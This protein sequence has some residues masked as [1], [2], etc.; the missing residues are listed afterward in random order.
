MPG[1]PDKSSGVCNHS[2][3]KDLKCLATIQV[4]H[5]VSLV[6]E[7]L[8]SSSDVLHFKIHISGVGWLK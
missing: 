8:L 6:G 7:K 4:T 5:R 3:H 2:Q 1:K